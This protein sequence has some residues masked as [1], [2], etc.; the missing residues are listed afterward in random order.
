LLQGTG[1][2]LIGV[3]VV[4]LLAESPPGTLSS[5]IAG[6]ALVATTG[7]AAVTAA[8]LVRRQPDWARRLGL[9]AAGGMLFLAWI[10]TTRPSSNLFTVLLG[11]ALLAVGSI[12]S[13]Q[14]LRW[15][16]GRSSGQTE[17]GPDVA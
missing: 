9:M 13:W 12:V 14:L 7:A 2:A 5:R 8:R 1:W 4:G 17:N 6:A 16:P 15:R 11:V 10:W 3:A